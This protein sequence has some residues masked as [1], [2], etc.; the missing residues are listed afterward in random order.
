VDDVVNIYAQMDLLGVQPNIDLSLVDLQP[1]LPVDE[2]L[3]ARGYVKLVDV[4]TL[5]TFHDSV[6]VCTIFLHTDSRVIIGACSS[7]SI[8]E[9]FIVV[10]N[11]GDHDI[12]TFRSVSCQPKAPVWSFPFYRLRFSDVDCD[13]VQSRVRS[14]LH[15]LRIPV[16]ALPMTDY[17]YARWSQLAS[18][19]V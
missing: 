10:E 15:G 4:A 19:L 12:V 3:Y 16:M 11:Y 2:Q 9:G 1:G 14:H 7:A 13:D 6:A 5:P 17:T 8:K 18:E